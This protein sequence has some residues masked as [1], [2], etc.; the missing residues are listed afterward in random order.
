MHLVNSPDAASGTSLA[1]EV[2]NAIQDPFVIKWTESYDRLSQEVNLIL[3]LP[4]GG[5]SSSSYAVCYDAASHPIG[6]QVLVGGRQ[7][8]IFQ[9]EKISSIVIHSTNLKLHLIRWRRETRP[10]G[11]YEG[12]VYDL[13]PGTAPPIMPPLETSAVNLPGGG[14][15]LACGLRWSILQSYPFNTNQSTPIFYHIGRESVPAGS[16]SANY[17]QSWTVITEDEP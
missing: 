16:N 7:E 13:R 9:G 15:T 17:G 2:T 11:D 5:A 3:T 12:F 6:Y 1:L 10:F 8:I 14:S 4:N